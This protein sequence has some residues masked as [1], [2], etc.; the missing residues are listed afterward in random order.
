MK[1]RIPAGIDLEDKLLYGL[2][3]ARLAY[4][5]VLVIGAIWMLRQQW[6][7]PLR[8]GGA[9]TLLGLG[10]AVGWMRRG[11]RHLDAWAADI[12]RH[13][14]RRYRVEFHVGAIAHLRSRLRSARGTRVADP[15]AKGSEAVGA[16]RLRVHLLRERRS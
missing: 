5:T 6:P 13:V 4:V 12:A 10:L 1:A 2:S 16:L 7:M 8:F 3:P 15:L 9:A 14:I 11:G